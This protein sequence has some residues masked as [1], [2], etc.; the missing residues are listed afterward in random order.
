MRGFCVQQSIYGITSELRSGETLTHHKDRFSRLKA[1][2]N[3]F[4][5][6]AG[7]V[8]VPPILAIQ[9]RLIGGFD[10]AA[11]FAVVFFNFLFVFFLF[12]LRGSLLRKSVLL[13]AGNCVGT[14]WYLVQFSLEETILLLNMESLETLLLVARPF[15]DFV[16]IVVVWSVSL[17]MVTPH[18]G[19]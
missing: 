4:H 3:L 18:R 17:S 16:W 7:S 14:L 5:M 13:V 12:P 15:V 2:P 8:L 6:L 11:L 9:V 10:L 1:S 19:R